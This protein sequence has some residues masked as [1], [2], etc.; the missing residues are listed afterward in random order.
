MARKLISA[1]NAGELS[2][3]LDARLDIEKYQNGCRILENCVPKIYGGAFGRA[4]ME[5]MGA[6]KHADKKCRLIEFIFSAT[7]NFILEFGHE[8]IRFWSNGVQ[9]ESS[10]GVPL[11][12]ASVYTEDDLFFIQYTQINDIMYLVDAAHPVQKLTRVSDTSWTIEEVVWKYPTLRDENITTTTLAASATTG[13][14]ITVTASAALFSEDMVGGYFQIAHRRE[15]SHLQLSLGANGTSAGLRMLGGYQVQSYGTWTATIEFQ[16]K[17]DLGDWETVWSRR[18]VSDR[19]ILITGEAEE[20]ETFRFRVVGWGAAT[21]SPR[22]LLEA[23]DSR[24]YGLVK[25]TGYTSPTVVTADVVKDLHDTAATLLWSEGAWSDHRGH[26]RTVTLH[27]QALVFGGC[28]SQPLTVWGSTLGD[29]ENF[30]RSSLADAAY[31]KLIGSTRGNAIVWL[32][33]LSSG[34]GIGTQGDEW[35][36]RSPDDSRISASAGQITR[37]SSYGAAYVMPIMGNDSVMFVQRGR[38]KLREFVYVFDKDGYSAP[39]LTLLAEHIGSEG[40]K[41]LAFASTPDPVVW[42]VTEDGK[43]LSM[44]FERDQ[45]VVGWSRHITQGTVESVAVI[46][47]A[48]GEADEV[49]IVAKRTVAPDLPGEAEV[50][51]IER[52]DPQKWSKLEDDDSANFIYSDAAK[53]LELSPA[54]DTVTGLDHLEGLEVAI[55]A[56][57]FVHPRRRVNNGELVLEREASRV[58]VGLPFTP[59]LQ[60]SRSEIALEDGSAQGRVWASKK[61]VVRFWK[62]L[63]GQYADN[64]ESGFYDIPARNVSTSTDE[65]EPL[66]TGDREI[67]MQGKHIGGIDV[68]LRQTLPLPFHVLAMIPVFDI[69]GA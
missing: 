61:A 47:G 64:P 4:G 6:A 60:P 21:G 27:E 30:Q 38:R 35:I 54:S 25:I 32:A 11:E 20:E 37:Q 59:R 39:D 22:V 5:Y 28:E 9:V 41:Q 65:S 62:S 69:S 10:P 36:I 42:A 67:S 63:G 8:Y 1:F 52:I 2:P 29:F 15:E 57:G 48:A 34:L 16:R 31:A 55:L 18:G 45:S 43:L 19:N 44:T 49:W 14:G 24:I 50:R 66:F 56:D 53:N 12:I 33:S 3:L 17:N 46:Y 7:T 58:V 26:P 51:Y 23:S 40:F 13:S 68:T